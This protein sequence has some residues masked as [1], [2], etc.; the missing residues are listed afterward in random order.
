M[1]LVEIDL[2]LM[3]RALPPGQ[4]DLAREALERV[5]GVAKSVHDLSHRLHPAKLRLI[6]L[7]AAV[8]GLERELSRGDCAVIVTHDNVPAALPPDVTLCLFRVIQE[9]L[10]NALKYSKASGVKVHLSGSSE[11]VTA[12]I[13]DDG[14]GF[15]VAAAWGKGLGLISMRERLEAIG[16]TLQIH[17]RPGEGTRL[18]IEVPV[19]MAQSS[20]SVAV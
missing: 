11:G 7:V 16:G 15:D 19:A 6:G 18:E 13:V 12:T 1:A 3:A 17:S 4:E 14:V 2:D 20:E 9:A 5:Q 10:Q 8:H